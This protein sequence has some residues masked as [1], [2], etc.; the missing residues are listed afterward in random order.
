MDEVLKFLI[1]AFLIFAAGLTGVL[2]KKNLLIIFMGVELMLCGA[3]LVFAAFARAYGNMDGLVFCFFIMA[4]AA[5]EVAFALAVIVQF[6]KIRRSVS[7][8]DADTL[9]D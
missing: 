8:N 7:A 5:A 6:F 1:P 9:G 4:I 3:M 2:L